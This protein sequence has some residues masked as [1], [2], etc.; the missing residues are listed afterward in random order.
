MKKA[1]VV[2]NRLRPAAGFTLVEL[3]AAVALLVI[4]LAIFFVVFRE[5]GST[6][7]IGQ[8]RVECYRSVRAIFRLLEE[9]ITNTFLMGEGGTT[10][11]F[12][13]EDGVIPAFLSPAPDGDSDRLTLT[14]P[15]K[16]PGTGEPGFMEVRFSRFT[17]DQGHELAADRRHCFFRA[18]DDNAGSGWTPGSPFPSA[19]FTF[20]ASDPDPTD[21]DN[22]DY[23]RNHIA[24]LGLTD[25]QFE[26]LKIDQ[27]AVPPEPVWQDSWAPDTDTYDPDGPGGVAAQPSLPLEV[28]VTIR[29]PRGSAYRGSTNPDDHQTF[30]HVV[31]L[32]TAPWAP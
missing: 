17:Y 28:R 30:T 27:S 8:D 29:L 4:L 21:D 3:I 10:Y 24:V 22:N 25:L 23:Y 12:A 15:R 31:H 19:I 11:G 1:S 9:D 14:R 20:D 18:V 2:M 5:A 16:A 32:P 7:A 13:G 6:V 26:Y